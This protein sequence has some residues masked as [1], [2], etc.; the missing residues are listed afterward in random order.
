M[1]TTI[2]GSSGI[3]LV[4]PKVTKG[5]TDGSNVPAGYVGEYISS[6]VPLASQLS[7]T[8]GNTLSVTSISLTAGDWD[9]SGAVSFYPTLTTNQTLLI[10]SISLVNATIDATLGRDI[11]LATPPQVT[12]GTINSIS[13][14]SVRL[15]LSATTTVYLCAVAVFTASTMTVYG[16]ISAR[17]VA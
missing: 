10:G 15:S 6:D 12:G 11:R 1:T 8:S 5:V 4:E 7:L 13:T 2:S 17:R 3:N 16:N 14:K 9:V